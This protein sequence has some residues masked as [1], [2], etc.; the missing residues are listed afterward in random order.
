MDSLPA[1][2]Q[3][4]PKN[5]GV[6]SLSLLQGIFPTQ[7][8]SQGLLHYRWVLY[9]LNYRNSLIQ[10]TFYKNEIYTINNVLKPYVSSLSLS[11]VPVLIYQLLIYWSVTIY[12]VIYLSQ[13]QR[14]CFIAINSV[15][16]T[17]LILQ[18]NYGYV[19]LFVQRIRMK[20]EVENRSI[21]L[22]IRLFKKKRTGGKEENV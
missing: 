20:V 19:N 13:Y 8:S 16:L 4:K 10:A 7:E 1:E 9:Q 3:G 14:K 18:S 15:L 11:R 17:F 21:C 5:T 2:P 22:L 12:L 6:G